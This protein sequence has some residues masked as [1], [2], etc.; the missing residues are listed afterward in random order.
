MITARSAHQFRVFSEW[1]LLWDFISYHAVFSGLF[2]FKGYSFN[3]NFFPRQNNLLFTF[4][5]IIKLMAVDERLTWQTFTGE[6][7]TPLSHK[8]DKTT[9][10]K[11][12][13]GLQH[14]ASYAAFHKDQIL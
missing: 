4:E 12:I 1:L 7:T 6:T 3:L 13:G 11:Q 10:E 2:D 9:T 14:F 8:Q 5:L